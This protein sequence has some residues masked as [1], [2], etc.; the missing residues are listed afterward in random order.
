MHASNEKIRRSENIPS[1]RRSKPFDLQEDSI[2]HDPLACN[3]ALKPLC[4]RGNI[5][6]PLTEEDWPRTTISECAKKG[7]EK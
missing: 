5:F 2:S 6:E 7:L 1:D 3:P 4:I